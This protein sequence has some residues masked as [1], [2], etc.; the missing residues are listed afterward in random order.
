VQRRRRGAD[1]EAVEQHR[2][3][4]DARGQDRA[5]HRGDFA[6]AQTSQD[7]ERIA[8]IIAVQ[9]DRRAHGLGLALEPRVVDARAAADPIL[10]LAAVERVIDR[11]GDRGA[12]D[13]HFAQAQQIGL[14]GERLHAEGHR[15]RAGL[16][17][18]RRLSRD[19]AGRLIERQFEHF[20]RNVEGFADLIDRRAAAGEIGDHRLRH[21]LRERRNAVGDDAVVAGEN[22]DQRRLDMR[23]RRALPGREPFHDLFEPPQRARRLGQLRLARLDGGE[24]RRVGLGHR[25]D[26]GADIVEWAR[27]SIHDRRP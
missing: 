7:F 14:R 12:A 6:P 26:E 8:Q 21:G 20:Q 13:A 3:A 27:R 5:R 9:R 1:D 15:R 4:P 10:R 25:G 16:F 22:R 2:H 11:G 23:A 17:I 19:V 24:R 18:E